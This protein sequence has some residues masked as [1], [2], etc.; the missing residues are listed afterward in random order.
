MCQ[1]LCLKPWSG[2]TRKNSVLKKLMSHRYCLFKGKRDPGPLYTKKPHLFSKFI[3]SSLLSVRHYAR[4]VQVI[5]SV[6][7]RDR[8]GRRFLEVSNL[9]ILQ[10]AWISFNFLNSFSPGV[11]LCTH[12]RQEWAPGDG[13]RERTHWA[14][15][16]RAVEGTFHFSHDHT[17][18]EKP[19]GDWGAE[20]WGWEEVRNSEDG[21][22]FIHHFVH[23]LYTNDTEPPF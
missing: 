5:W 17:Q 18:E 2:D 22:D 21:T 16:R 10:N 11:P 8:S 19:K 23:I 12:L 7:D 6:C 20:P 4:H 9:L 3:S 14:L 13:G 1:A 15:C